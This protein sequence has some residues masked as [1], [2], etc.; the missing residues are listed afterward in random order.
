[1]VSREVVHSIGVGRLDDS[2]FYIQGVEGV[3]RVRAAV[4]ADVVQQA[5]PFVGGHVEGEVHVVEGGVVGFGYSG[6]L[7]CFEVEQEYVVADADAD[8]REAGA[9][10]SEFAV[11]VGGGADNLEPFY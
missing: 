9:E 10:A 7:E 11:I 3:F 8:L 6:A 5:S 2:V 4:V 1:M